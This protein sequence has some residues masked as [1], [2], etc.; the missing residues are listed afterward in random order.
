VLCRGLG[1]LRAISLPSAF[2]RRR[3][4]KAVG[5]VDLVAGARAGVGRELVGVLAGDVGE[6]GRP[7]QRWEPGG[8]EGPSCE[9][10]CTPRAQG[11]ARRLDDAA[12]RTEPTL[13]PLEG[14][15][16]RAGTPSDA[17]ASE[18]RT[19]DSPGGR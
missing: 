8:C 15:L 13:R 18:M 19:P 12:R 2:D 11:G 9:S 4:G 5:I 10:W 16:R 1:D 14:F 17:P 7:V 3:E 6:R